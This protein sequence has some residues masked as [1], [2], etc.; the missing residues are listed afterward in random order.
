VVDQ[1]NSRLYDQ[2]HAFVWQLGADLL[3][4]LAA[5]RGERILDLG[6]GTG[7]LTA[8]I[9]D[10]GAR[11]IGLDAS[12][13]MV[14]QASAEYPH[15]TFV[16]GDGARFSFPEPFDAVFSNAAL[17]WIP[18]ASEAAACIAAALRPGGRLVAE[19]GGQGNVALIVAAIHQ[20]RESAGFPSGRELNPWY[21]PSVAEYASVLEQQG[22]EVTYAHLFERPTPLEGGAQGLAAWLEMF[23]GAFLADLAPHRREGVVA[24]VEQL[25]RPRLFRDGAWTA[26]YRR[27]RIVAVKG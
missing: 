2:R 14:A 24:V 27:L 18:R 10:S 20:A 1:W 23:A 7:H 12:A 4:L 21:F 3:D 8:R 15:L 19:L 17:H 6:A 16:Q 22:L 5:S 11:V 26:D 25:A 9:A 13:A